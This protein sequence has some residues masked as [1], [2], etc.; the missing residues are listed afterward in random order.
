M[1]IQGYGATGASGSPVLDGDGRVV[2]VVFGGRD[3]GDGHR[4][5]VVPS[6]AVQRLLDAVPDASG[7]GGVR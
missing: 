6:P 3:A 2:G 4:L 7:T 5:L 1:V